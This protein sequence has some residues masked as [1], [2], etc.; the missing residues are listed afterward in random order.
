MEI[1]IRDVTESN[2]DDMPE[3]CRSCTYWSLPE[4]TE[5]MKI[6]VSKRKKR[7]WLLQTIREFG[8]CGKILYHNGVPIGYAE[9]GP[10]S[11]FSQIKNYKSQP[12]GKVEEGIVFLACLYIVNQSLRGRGFGEE[13]LNDIIA[14][15]K[16]RNFKALETYAR[17]GS[18]NNPSGPVE[19]Y[20]KKGFYVKNHNNPEFPLMRL[21]L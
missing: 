20:L 3:P 10:S 15:L 12:V 16:G 8:S 1:V 19:F 18:P 5:R 21:D 14:D 7:R 17:R 4:E 2:L 13:L 11:R 9:Y 6:E